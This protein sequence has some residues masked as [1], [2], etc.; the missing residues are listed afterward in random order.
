MYMV[1][2]IGFQSRLMHEGTANIQSSLL[3]K[4]KVK[5]P[6]GEWHQYSFGF[7]LLILFK[8]LDCNRIQSEFV[9]G[10][11]VICFCMMGGYL[12]LRW[13]MFIGPY[14]I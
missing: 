2:V 3:Q 10:D 13:Y 14:N 8:N 5:K 1:Q 9:S 11:S 12:N 7:Y 4:N 6:D